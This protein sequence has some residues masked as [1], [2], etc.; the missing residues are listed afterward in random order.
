MSAACNTPKLTNCF[1]K[2]QIAIILIGLSLLPI[3]SALTVF[4]WRL[5]AGI[6]IRHWLSALILAP[7]SEELTFRGLIQEYLS[8]KFNCQAPPK[9]ITATAW[10]LKMVAS[11]YV[12]ISITFI[13]V[14]ILFTSLHHA[15]NAN[16]WYLSGVF[17]CGMLFSLIKH[18]TTTIYWPILIHSYYNLVFLGTMSLLGG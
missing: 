5:I 17:A 2:F 11:N 13:L 15:I 7:L 9:Q 6:Q 1:T 10:P 18:V 12:G 4:K 8:A 14:N 16:Y 3:F